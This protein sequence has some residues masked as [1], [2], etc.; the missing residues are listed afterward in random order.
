[1]L[2]GDNGFRIDSDSHPEI[3]SDEHLTKSEA[4]A[5]V[6]LAARYHVTVIPEI[7]MPGHM[8][9]VL[10]RHPEYRLPPDP[11]DTSSMRDGRLD[12]TSDAA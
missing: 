8:N 5:I 10:A 11:N 2:G 3:V 12:V 1:N 4:S 6:E 7:D 9:A